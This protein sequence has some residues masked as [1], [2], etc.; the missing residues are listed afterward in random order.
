MNAGR[1]LLRCMPGSLATGGA[2]SRLKAEMAM[3]NVMLSTVVMRADVAVIQQELAV[4]GFA[5]VTAARFIG[6]YQRKRWTHGIYYVEFVEIRRRP[7][8]GLNS[9][10]SVTVG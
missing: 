8:F 4:F 10:R 6:K 3:A 7:L 9:C 1:V 2:A 5:C